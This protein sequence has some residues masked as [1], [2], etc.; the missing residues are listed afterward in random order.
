VE[1][2]WLIVGLGNP[3]REY[4]RTRHNLGFTL[5]DVLAEQCGSLVKRDEC[6][7]LIGRAEVENEA[8]E[9]AKKHALDSRALVRNHARQVLEGLGAA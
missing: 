9:L 4:E 3:G 8:V 5:I 7:S 6:R 1:T 2:H